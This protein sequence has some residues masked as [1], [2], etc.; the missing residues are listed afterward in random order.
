MCIAFNDY[1]KIL[2]AFKGVQ[3]SHSALKQHAN[4]LEAALGR[5][6]TTL[7]EMAGQMTTSSQE[8]AAEEERLRAKLQEMTEALKKE[9]EASK[10]LQKQV[11]P[12][13]HLR[14]NWSVNHLHSGITMGG[15]RG[16]PHVGVP[17]WGCRI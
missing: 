13:Y 10:K 2:L 17:I 8:H 6:E 14:L 1:K 9:K 3:Q 7:A 4:L 11:R 5:R 12:E 16:V 15:A